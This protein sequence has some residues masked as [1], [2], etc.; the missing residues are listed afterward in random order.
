MWLAAVTRPGVDNAARAPVRQ[1]HDPC[2]R[3]WDRVIKVPKYLNGTKTFGLTFKEG[4]DRLQFT[5]TQITPRRVAMMY[6]G[7]V[8]SATSRIKH[9]VTFSTTKTEHVATAEGAIE[10]LFVKIVVCDLEK[11]TR[12]FPASSFCVA[13]TKRCWFGEAKSTRRTKA[14]QPGTTGSWK[15]QRLCSCPPISPV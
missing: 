14:K 8:V 2:K 6:A 4:H 13:P 15:S 11:I 5:V 7:V 12:T 9:S 1:S 10:G 3:H